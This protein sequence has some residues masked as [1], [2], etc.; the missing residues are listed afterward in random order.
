MWYGYIHLN[1][2]MHAKR[3]A[4]AADWEEAWQSNFVKKITRP[5]SAVSRDNAVETIKK[6]VRQDMEFQAGIKAIKKMFDGKMLVSN[7]DSPMSDS[8]DHYEEF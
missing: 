4:S 6:I 1:G 5:F 7:V 8:C 2:F 3:I